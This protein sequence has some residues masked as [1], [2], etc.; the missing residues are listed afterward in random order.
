M[1]ALALG[2]NDYV[3]KGS[4]V[5]SIDASIQALRGELIPKILQFFQIPGGGS[6][7]APE[8]AARSVPPGVSGRQRS[9]ALSGSVSAVAAVAEAPRSTGRPS[10]AFVG[11]RRILAIGVSTG[12]PTALA[13]I[14]PQFPAHLSVPV[15]VVQHM[16]PMFTGLLAERLAH[17]SRIAVVEA[18][19]SMV[20]E[21]GKAY[22][23]PGDYHLSLRRQGK[24]VI[25]T[26]NQDPP[27]NSCRP[28]VDVLFRSVQE[29]YGGA[30]MAVVLTGMG[31]D[32]LRGA[33]QMRAA[34]ACVLAQ[35]EASS[36]VWG[37]PGAVVKAGLADAVV[38]LQSVV[39]EIMKRLPA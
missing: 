3:T 19:D 23:A 31:Q 35:D 16:P 10:A 32:G 4:M 12:G 13:E 26:L 17:K 11:Q 7:S 28:A 34:G 6:S 37:M 36:V 14:F 9:G 20:L 33:E 22:I 8:R 30:A 39:P 18:R 15:V 21:A 5:G 2:A 38:N 29:I 25:C 24:E 27:E 1:D